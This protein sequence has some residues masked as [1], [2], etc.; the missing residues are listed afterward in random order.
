MIAAGAWHTPLVLRRSGIGH[1]RY[2]GE[3]LTLHPGFR[4][5]GRFREKVLGTLFRTHKIASFVRNLN[6]HG[7]YKTMI[8]KFAKIFF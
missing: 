3:G 6:K 5:L 1:P 7:F 2:V 8:A 4:V